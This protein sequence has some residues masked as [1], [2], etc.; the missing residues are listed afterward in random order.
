MVVLTVLNVDLGLVVHV[1][2]LYIRNTSTIYHNLIS[3]VDDTRIYTKIHDVSDCN[4]L[5]QDLNHIYDNH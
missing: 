5:Q 4:L 2:L 1:Y 3:F